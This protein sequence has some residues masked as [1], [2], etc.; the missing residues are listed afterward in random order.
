[1][2]VLREI[3]AR[4]RVFVDDGLADEIGQRHFGGGDEPEFNFAVDQM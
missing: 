3:A 1:M 4:Q 2:D